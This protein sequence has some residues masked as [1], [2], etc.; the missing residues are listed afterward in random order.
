MKNPIKTYS[1]ALLAMAVIV[2]A[3]PLLAQVR[4]PI[5][6]SSPRVSFKI[7]T[8]PTIGDIGNQQRR[9]SMILGLEYSHPFGKGEF[10]AVAEMRDYVSN[11][12]EATQFSP[13]DWNT[14][15]YHEKTGYAPNGQRGYITAFTRN[16]ASTVPWANAIAS[17]MRFDSVDMRQNPLNGAVAKL[18]YRYRVESLP[19]VGNLGVQAGLTLSY[20]TS[21]QYAD[22]ALHVLD[23][24]D[25]TQNGAST[26]WTAENPALDAFGRLG[27]EYYYKT[28][29][30]QK[31]VPGF[32][33]GARKLLTDTLFFEMNISVLGHA[34]LNY[35]PFSYSGVPAHWESTTKMKT[36]LEFIAGLRF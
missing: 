8:A 26:N 10:F 7:G 32:F 2:P 19:F 28:E 24:R 20:L 17:D 3:V 27:N 25:M 34:N 9:E 30:E 36:G 13:F 14:A 29:A 35:V 22:G 18:A 6:E 15:V 23:Y 31:F 1:R 12:Y 33:I 21:K 5:N 4:K 11:T 16:P